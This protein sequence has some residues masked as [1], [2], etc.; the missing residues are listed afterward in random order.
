MSNTLNNYPN[1]AIKFG[2]MILW[3]ERLISF[4][5]L[6]SDTRFYLTITTVQFWH[7]ITTSKILPLTQLFNDWRRVSNTIR[8]FIIK[9]FNILS[10]ENNVTK[11]HREG[12]QTNREWWNVCFNS[13]MVYVLL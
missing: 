5:Y 9:A 8:L 12:K 7:K 11:T 2:R 3:P 4:S 10:V 6:S 1:L 13:L